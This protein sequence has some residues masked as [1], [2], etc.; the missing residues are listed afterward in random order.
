MLYVAADNNPPTGARRLLL[1]KFADDGDKFE[2]WVG[3]VDEAYVVDEDKPLKVEQTRA[4]LAK[5]LPKD[6]PL[7]A[8]AQQS[9][10]D[11]SGADF[12]NVTLKAVTHPERGK[13]C[14]PR[15]IPADEYE[16]ASK[17]PEATLLQPFAFLYV[18]KI[19]VEPKNVYCLLGHKSELSTDEGFTGEK[20]KDQLAGWVDI[21]SL[22]LWTT[23]EAFEYRLEPAALEYRRKGTRPIELFAKDKDLKDWAAWEMAGRTG[24][25]PVKSVYKEDLDPKTAPKVMTEPWPAT[26]MRYPILASYPL[27]PPGVKPPT[28]IDGKNWLGY[29]LCMLGKADDGKSATAEE[30]EKLKDKV[31][32]AVR[33]TRVFELMLVIDTTGS[34]DPV[35]KPVMDGVQKVVEELKKRAKTE[36]TTDLDH[37][38]LRVGVVLYKDFP[39]Q[40]SV[41]LTKD[42]EEFFDVM[43][44]EGLKKFKDWLTGA[45]AGGAAGGGDD[46]EEPFEGIKVAVHKFL[47]PKESKLHT[48]GAAPVIAIFG[49]SGNHVKGDATAKSTM[50]SYDD[51]LKMLEAL[52]KDNLS[53]TGGK[54]AQKEVAKIQLHSVHAHLHKDDRTTDY[55]KKWD[56]QMP[57]LAKKSGGTVHD[58]DLYDEASKDKALDAL[59]AALTKTLDTRRDLLR[60][61]IKRLQQ[62]FGV[63]G[64]GSGL[65]DL[66]VT[67]IAKERLEEILGPGEVDRIRKKLSTAFFSVIHSVEQA[68]GES[69]ALSRMKL[70][71]LLTDQEFLKVQTA[72]QILGEGL[73]EE[74]KKGG[75]VGDKVEQK[76][77]ELVIKIM[78][79]AFGETPTIKRVNELMAKSMSEIQ[80]EVNQLPV[81][82]GCLKNQPKSEDDLKKLVSILKEKANLMLDIIRTQTGDK[83]RFFPAGVATGE[84]HIWLHKTELP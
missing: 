23:R 16:T 3:W 4:L 56:E 42:S 32:E 74:V 40:D 79:A 73:D 44:D 7:A 26:W 60:I 13:A 47:D 9:L 61:E 66:P 59:V 46:L 48:K 82:F 20:F 37:I 25:S 2:S 11:A 14:F 63:T 81:Q 65:A 8:K 30:I 18:Y 64:E 52:G 67:R 51:V 49:D 39:D 84:N 35:F 28:G 19:A 58:V 27:N 33:G 53:G 41:Y 76:I 12:K 36:K 55:S 1:G 10:P 24:D 57:E 6:H 34:M 38:Q 15:P 62:E 78:L 54:D 69:E 17:T 50:L 68:P 21:D 83:K 22:I 71:I 80:K 29:Q 5:V 72:C 70:C 43:T 31:N 75:L 45:T 77:K